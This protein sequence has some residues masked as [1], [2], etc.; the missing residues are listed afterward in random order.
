MRLKA[1][2][3]VYLLAPAGAQTGPVHS[4]TASAG[5]GTSARPTRKPSRS[6]GVE[7]VL[8]GYRSGTAAAA[9]AVSEGRPNASR[10]ASA[11]SWQG[12]V[13]FRWRLG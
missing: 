10:S 1:G 7:H 13:P 6:A 3:S 5:T 2:S 8:R 11:K 4:L 9:E 12:P